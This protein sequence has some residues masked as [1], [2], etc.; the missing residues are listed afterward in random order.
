MRDTSRTIPF[1]SAVGAGFALSMAGFVRNRRNL[2]A[3]ALLGLPVLL[4][5]FYRLMAARFPAGLGGAM[6][7]YGQIVALYLVRQAVPLAAL[8]LASALVAD[9]VEGKTI[10]FLLTRPVRREALLIGKFGAY[11]AGAAILALPSVLLAFVI[12][13]SSEGF[14]SVGAHSLGMLRDLL[15]VVLGLAV[16]GA[17]FTFL[18]VLLRRP[19]VPGL[20]ILFV[21][22][23]L[24]NVPGWLPRLTISAWLRSL[25]PYTIPVEGLEA[26]FGRALPVG[27]SVVVLLIL[28]TLFASAAAFLFGRREYV[29]SQ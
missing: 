1:G 28:T 27:T 26:L 19:V 8:F 21:W 9:E 4:A 16:Y 15:V 25:V 17:L 5:L 23:T 10:T 20:A 3:A 24:A 29:L 14:A 6:D 22:E 11:L 2:V 13:A 18:G 7:V 12:L